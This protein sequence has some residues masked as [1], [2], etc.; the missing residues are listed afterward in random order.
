MEISRYCLKLLIA[1]VLCL[2]ASANS[3]AADDESKLPLLTTTLGVRAGDETVE[4][5]LDILGPIHTFKNGV[6]FLN[7]RAGLQDGGENEFN[8]GIGYRHLIPDY[9]LVLGANLYLDSRKTGNGNRFNQVGAGLE[10]LSEWI[11]FRANYYYPEDG[12]PYP[13]G[14]SIWRDYITTTD[15]HITTRKTETITTNT[16]TTTIRRLFEQFE[17][18]LEGYD[19]ELG[20]KLPVPE[21]LPEVRLFGG[22]YDFDNPYGGDIN[23]W[24]GRLE[25]RAG[26]YLTFDAEVYEDD[27]FNGSDYFIGARLQIPFDTV[28]PV[29][30][31]K[32]VLTR[33]TRRS[34]R[35]RMY[36]D[37]VKRDVR[38]QTEDSD[39]LENEA[40][41]TTATETETHI[42]SRTTTTQAKRTLTQRKELEL[43]FHITFADGDNATGEE[44][45]TAEHPYDTVQEAVNN[46][47]ENNTIYVDSAA[48]DYNENVALQDHQVLTSAIALSDGGVFQTVTAPT[49][50]GGTSPAVTHADNTQ[51]IRINEVWAPPSPAPLNPPVPPDPPE[52]PSPPDPPGSPDPPDPPNPLE[53]ITFVDGDND[54]GVEDGTPEHPYNT[55]QEGVDSA[56]TG[57]PIFVDD[58]ADD[59]LENILLSDNQTLAST[60][61]LSD[62]NTYASLLPPDLD[63]GAG[64]AITL[65][66][67][68]T[69]ERINIVGGDTGIAGNGIGGT[70][71]IK[72]VTIE[73]VTGQG[74]DIQNSSGIF[75]IEL[76]TIRDSGGDGIHVATFAGDVTIVNTEIHNSGN[77]GVD[78]RDST[79]DFTLADALIH[80]TVDSAVSILNHDGSFTMNG[81]K[82]QDSGNYGIMIKDSIGE[83][84]FKNVIISEI[85]RDGIA[86]QSSIAGSETDLIVEGC[87]VIDN[88]AGSG[89][90]F[91]EG[92]NNAVICAHISDSVFSIA[93][94]LPAI[95]IQA[96]DTAEVGAVILNNII[97]GSNSFSIKAKT[98]NIGSQICLYATGNSDGLGNAPI[99]IFFLDNLANGTLGIT[100]GNNTNLSSD[101]NGVTVTPV[102]TVTFDVTCCP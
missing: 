43:A 89:G 101:N 73:N 50:N 48:G 53:G 40:Q 96:H 75:T 67:G 27:E 17:T 85:L 76:T 25:V 79:G 46:A 24:K 16:E 12:T 23:G 35:D 31:L 56:G 62:G 32:K 69:I 90:I 2:G 18:A 19:L 1:V 33:K 11:D 87:T 57:N 64:D 28:N 38:V 13:S 42:A 77:F 68:N 86:C 98:F 34:V 36:A 100:Q 54:T 61:L 4:G 41:K 80:T 10:C 14:H 70:T 30:V 60:M 9:D 88:D 95:D 81:G 39:F 93:N 45:G 47:G 97:N 99:G 51:V 29:E 15:Y 71:L 74:I 102:G 6:I 3:E 63:G 49:I 92:E 5:F 8:A 66:D 26:R 65:A 21:E 22:W 44:D 55:I 82:I 52:S 94:T 20:V 72:N 58:A 91:L 78:I 84:T 59:Y 37:M 83:Y 7:P